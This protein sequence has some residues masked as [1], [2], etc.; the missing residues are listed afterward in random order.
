[1]EFNK[2]GKI[3]L[4]IGIVVTLLVLGLFYFII[5]NKNYERVFADLPPEKLSKVATSLEE[6]GL[7]FEYPERGAGLL[8]EKSRLAQ[9]RIQLSKDGVFQSEIAGLEIFGEAQ[10]AMSDFYQKINYQRALQ[11]ELERSIL[12]ISGVEAARVHLAI[13]REKSFSR[14]ETDV[15][16][17]VT[18]TIASDDTVNNRDIVYVVKQ[19]VANSVIDLKVDNVA[20]LDSTG[21]VLG[22]DIG[23]GINEALTLKQ[24]IERSIEQKVRQLLSPY[25]DVFD[26]GISS[27][28]TINND[29]VSETSEGLDTTEEPVVLKRTTETTEGTKKTAKSTVTNEEFSYKSVTRAVDYQKGTLERMT[30]SVMVPVSDH[31]TQDVLVDL[32][33]NA[34]GIDEARGDKLTV[35]FM[36]K[37]PD[38]DV[39]QMVPSAVNEVPVTPVVSAPLGSDGFEPVAQT[40]AGYLALLKNEEAMIAIV[41]SIFILI[42]LQFFCFNRKASL[43]ANEQKQV[44]KDVHLWLEGRSIEQD[45]KL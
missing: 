14:K 2:N 30:V 13:P 37:E 18:L 21:Q 42:A 29:Q 22:G 6:A 11:G 40:D 35:A 24:E 33:S 4:G 25:Y 23:L 44:M 20:V 19:L 17:A 12:T 32:L 31:F 28:A 15:K 3:L 41:V 8:I 9:A 10:R 45:V 36:P 16:A 7:T 27:W 43:T 1:M 34:L 5:L 38:V 39:S 26:I